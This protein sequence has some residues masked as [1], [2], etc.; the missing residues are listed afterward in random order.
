MKK[1][2]VE[3]WKN[4]I[5]L[6]FADFL[7][8]VDFLWTVGFHEIWKKY[9]LKV[10]EDSADTIGY[11]VNKKNTGIYS[12]VTTNSF[13]AS[14]IINGAGTGGIVCF[15]DYKLYEKANNGENKEVFITACKFIGLL[16]ESSEDWFNYKKNKVS[17]S[18]NEILNKIESRNSARKNKNYK[19][20]DK[21]R[22]ELLDK[23]V[24]IEDKDGKTIWKFK[25]AK[26]DY[27]YL[28]QH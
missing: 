21:I 13:Y 6:P 24:L 16:N 9:K 3:N 10:I 22:D 14:H 11:T 26:K 20:A 7:W 5:F 1:L 2:T 15:N 18:D 28:I 19:E 25:W 4:H 23:G 8:S 12:D 27:T 17:I